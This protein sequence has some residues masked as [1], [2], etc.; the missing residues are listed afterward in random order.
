MA[1]SSDH[2]QHRRDPL[3]PAGE[4]VLFDGS[5]SLLSIVLEPL[6]TMLSLLAMLA[7]TLWVLPRV[8]GRAAPTW[9]PLGI[10]ALFVLRAVWSCVLWACRRYVLTDRRVLAS[11]GVIR[12]IT[13]DVPLKNIQH[14]R[15]IRSRRERL[16]GIGTLAID[17]SGSGET[18]LYWFMIDRP[19]AALNA[20]RNAMQNEPVQRLHEP[21]AQARGSH[22]GNPMLVL[23]LIGGIGA[24]KSAV[25]SSLARRGYE[26]IDSDKEAKAALDLPHVRAQLVSWWGADII[27]PEGRVDRAKV[28]SIV[29]S[30]ATQRRRLEEL[31]HPIVKATRAAMVARARER[32][33][34]GVVVDAPLL[35]EAGVDKEC[36]AVL[37]VDAPFEQR[38][39]RVKSGRGWT[40]EE[41]RR[42]E[43]AQTPLEEKRRR[44]DEIIVNDADLTTLDARVDA[45]LARLERR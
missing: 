20:V 27:N 25:A 12:R 32:G 4:R 37:F 16:S 11:V 8:T 5:P 6:G 18:E 35:L 15:V 28:A 24:G 39:E 36:D 30:D 22:S 43:S 19:D 1:S 45:A 44:A 29:F 41:L 26:V 17:T 3:I 42:R 2:P 13:V 7:L 33:C 40:E 34:R 9:L 23:G 10:T 38:L 14:L 31:V 21:E